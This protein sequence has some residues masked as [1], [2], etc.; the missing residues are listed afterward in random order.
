MF[1]TI[2]SLFIG[3]ISGL[4]VNG[5]CIRLQN[6][7]PSY[8]PPSI[9]I[10]IEQSTNYRFQ[11]KNHSSDPSTGLSFDSTFL[12]T[13][14]LLGTWAL[15]FFI[16]E[17][18]QQIIFYGWILV[19]F[20]ATFIIVSSI[21]SINRARALSMYNLWMIVTALAVIA[22]WQLYVS[23]LIDP[24]TVSFLN[25]IFNQTQETAG[26]KPI[27]I[28]NT[29]FNILAKFI[30]SLILVIVMF[31][32]MC[33]AIFL[34]ISP[35]ALQYPFLLRIIRFVQVPF[36]KGGITIHALFIII[37]FVFI[38]YGATWVNVLPGML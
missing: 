3:I 30:G 6:R 4:I 8:K 5:I 21:F 23:S 38:R 13:L 12:L 35:L 14:I 25:Q 7:E 16:H 20:F 9:N 18:R 29:A 34:M 28:N 11:Q 17:Y 26:I 32:T 2:N 1:D 36:T 15:L 31:F 24:E 37:A 27:P 33:Q 19:S 22:I 10:I